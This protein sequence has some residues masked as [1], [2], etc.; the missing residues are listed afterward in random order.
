[1]PTSTAKGSLAGHFL[2]T[3]PAAARGLYGPRMT[4]NAADLDA[5]HPLR[6]TLAALPQKGD[7]T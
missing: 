4:A 6:E 7:V 3:E 5:L 1:M 2:W